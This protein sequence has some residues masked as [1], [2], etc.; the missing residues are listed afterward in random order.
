[1][2]RL[3]QRVLEN[4]DVEVRTASNGFAAL[5]LLI[6]WG[7]PTVVV[8][9]YRMARMTGLELLDA[10]LERWPNART[11]LY[12]AAADSDIVLEAAQNRHKVLTKNA[13]ADVLR[14]AIMRAVRRPRNR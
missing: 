7:E 14:A 5:S 3:L 4:D 9:D 2:L 6:E 12:T 10:V 1:M 8:S 11:I 13:S